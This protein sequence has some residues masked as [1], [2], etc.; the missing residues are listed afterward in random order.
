MVTLRTVFCEKSQE[1]TYS[2]VSG[3]PWTPT[4]W[5]YTRLRRCEFTDWLLQHCSCGCTKDS[6]GQ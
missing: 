3:V 6:N 1:M 4:R 5:L 2:D